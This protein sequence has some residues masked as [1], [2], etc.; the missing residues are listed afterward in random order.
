MPCQ[1]PYRGELAQAQ[2]RAG[3]HK[4]PH[5][6]NSLPAILCLGVHHFLQTGGAMN[7]QNT[8]PAALPGRKKKNEN[9]K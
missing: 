5:G 9:R 2:T 8:T 1:R 3:V 6:A 4:T 7:E